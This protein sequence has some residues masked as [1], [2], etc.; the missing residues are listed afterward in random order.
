[1]ASNKSSDEYK[2]IAALLCDVSTSR[3]EVFDRRALRLTIQKIEKRVQEEGIAFLTKTLPRLGKMLDRALTGDVT[4]DAASL[5]FSSQYNSKLPRLLGELFNRVFSAD[6][7]VLPSPCVDSIKVLRQIL[8]VHYKYE[9]PYTPDEEQR[10]LAKFTK[11]EQDL[12]CLTQS[13]QRCADCSDASVS[14]G[15]RRCYA[16]CHSDTVRRARIRLS[17]VFARFDTQDIYPRHGPGAVSTR[18]KLWGKYQWTRVSPRIIQTYPLDAYFYASLGHVCDH[19]DRFNSIKIEESSARVILVPKDS[20]GPRLISCEPLDFQ[21]I[22]QGLGRAIVKHVESH[23]L[24]RK[25]VHFTDQTVNRQLALKG[26]IDGSYATLDLNEA[27]DR[28]TVGLV[29]LLFPEPLLTA[30]LNCRSLE[31]QLPDGSKLRLNKFAP[32]G[33][34]LCFPILA[35]TVWALLTSATVDAYVRKNIFVYGDDVIVP[36]AYAQDAMNILESFGL[37]INRDKS[38]TNG[39]FRESCGMD[40]YKGVDVTPVR[41]RTVWSVIPS[42]EVYT[43]WIAYANEL[44][45]RKYY[46]CYDLIV[47]RLF[48]VYGKIPSSDMHLACPSLIDVPDKWLPTQ[49]RSNNNLQKLQWR[50]RDVS[51]RS[52][53]KELDGWSMLLRYFAEARSK[54]NLYRSNN[55]EDLG[56]SPPADIQPFSVRRYT[57]RH[58]SLLKWCWR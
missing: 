48:A 23:P 17:R 33:S 29:R 21:W 40:A 54:S 34:A 6:G 38:C 12:L 56:S 37:K 31:T 9:M 19:L 18:E 2:L 5:R 16:Y 46:H 26:S 57:K 50:V 11:T 53:C 4:I 39:F 47:G 15:V 58:S 41:F 32:M 8:F 10:V 1:M 13:L 27:S 25:S 28:V 30:L 3:S 55:M 14:S 20:R 22:Q 44:Y 35:L 42:P 36:K 43:S 52:I 24:T 45:R 51:S 7:K 49:R